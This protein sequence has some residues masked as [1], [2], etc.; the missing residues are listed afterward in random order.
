MKMRNSGIMPVYY[1]WKFAEGE[2]NKGKNP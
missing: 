2:E 1:E